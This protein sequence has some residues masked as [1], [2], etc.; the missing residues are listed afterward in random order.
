CGPGD[1]LFQDIVLDRR[2]KR[3][4]GDAPPLS[5]SYVQGGQNRGS[6]V[7]RHARAHAIEWQTVKEGAHVVDR[8][9]RDADAPDLATSHRRVAVVSHLRRQVKF[10]A[11]ALVS[12][13]EEILEPQVRLLRGAKARVLTHRP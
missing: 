10:D 5:A 1:V 6:G 12:L 7:D 2:A 4:A 8:G 13:I 9:D 11:E 3:L